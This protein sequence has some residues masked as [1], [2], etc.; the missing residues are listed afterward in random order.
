MSAEKEAIIASNKAIM[1]RNQED[2][3]ELTEHDKPGAKLTSTMDVYTMSEIECWL[4][5][6]VC[7]FKRCLMSL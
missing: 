1:T 5:C 4:L 7:V 2:M 3:V 6:H